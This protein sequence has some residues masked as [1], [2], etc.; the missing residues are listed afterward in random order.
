[1]DN[2]K[3]YISKKSIIAAVALLGVT[4]ILSVFLFKTINEKRIMA[5]Y[6]LKKVT[7]YGDS[8]TQ[9]Y[10]Y[11]SVVDNYFHFIGH[12]S[13]MNGTQITYVNN[14][15]MAS[16]VRMNFE[17]QVTNIADD[18]EII[19]VMGGVNDWNHNA[20]IGD[21]DASY[22]NAKEGVFDGSTFAGACNM[23]FANLTEMYPSARIIVL[24][25][26][27]ASGAKYDLFPENN[28]IYN[29]QGLTSVD[30]GDVLCEIADMWGFD[31]MNI[32]RVLE[33]DENN[34]F[35]YSSD[36]MHFDEETGGVAAGNAVIDFLKGLDIK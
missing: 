17:S 23:M 27:F 28:G 5:Y 14:S 9:M 4:A 15:S 1:M 31:N 21:A 29:E 33:W 18:S 20:V 32:G 30:Y 12:N 34:I 25:T 26:P 10:F 6:N 8:I 7:W 35:D 36:G 11:C 16:S 22:E 3:K 19:F 24:G 2:I 13:G